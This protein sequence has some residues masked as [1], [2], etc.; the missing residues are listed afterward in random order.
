MKNFLA[1]IKSNKVVNKVCTEVA[2]FYT[3]HE[4]TILTGGIIGFSLATTTFAVKNSGEINR[5]INEAKSALN[6]CNTQ[7]EKNTIYSMTL[8]QL[9][10]LAAPIIIFQSLTIATAIHSKKQSDRRVAEI[11]GA[12]SIAQQAVTY[13]QNFQK[14][15]EESLGEKKFQKLQKEIDANTVYETSA[16]P[17]NSKASD[18]DQLFYEPI[19]GQLIWSSPDRMNL[20]WVKYRE[21]VRNSDDCFVPLCETFFDSI[22]ADPSVSAAEVFGYNNEDAVKMSDELY[23]DGTKVR[24]NGKEMSALKI[25]YYPTMRFFGEYTN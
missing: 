12:L 22:G 14:E 2:K 21:E 7:E 23:F 8:K 4:S 19:T 15:A 24:V 18:D 17:V 13:Y 3:E 5:I 20:G 16:S 6:C 10:P 11:A 25:N 9:A 1:P